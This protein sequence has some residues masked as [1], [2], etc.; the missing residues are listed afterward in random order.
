M[1]AMRRPAFPACGPAAWPAGALPAYEGGGVGTRTFRF[2]GALPPS[3][4]L[5]RASG[6]TYF[7]AAGVLQLAA[8][9]APRFD[10]RYAGGVWSLAGLL[11]EPQRT[12]ILP[13]SDAPTWNPS[14]LT[15][16]DDA[17]AAPDGSLS[18]D[19]LVP[20]T[21]AGT[22]YVTHQVTSEDVTV[23]WAQSY[24]VRSGPGGT[25]R[26]SNQF[27]NSVVSTNYIRGIYN[28][29]G[30]SV[31]SALDG[32]NGT[33]ATAGVDDCDD[34]IRCWLTGTPDTSGTA[35]RTYGSVTNG[36]DQLSFIGDGTSGVYLWGAQ[37]EKGAFPTS[38][39]PTAGS[40]VT[41]AA[42]L[43]T[44]SLD[45]GDYDLTATTPDGDF[46][47]SGITVSGGSYPFDWADFSGADGQRHLRKLT[48][49]IAA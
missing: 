47:A 1:G 32:G 44:L 36:S 40:A 33:G 42:D 18:G 34:W 46:V 26:H 22:H 37:L 35:I 16:T 29:T 2:D 30:K 43:L 12:N 48:A 21:D 15:I 8:T 24:F 31:V 25:Y 7:D 9:D 27:A 17:V 38:H 20:T 13:N 3:A 39:I 28:V 11:V 14:R 6:G 4:S 41:R 10:H 49:R 19:L 5:T 23:P 45:N